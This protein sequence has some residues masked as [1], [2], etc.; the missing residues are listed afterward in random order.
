MIYL[1]W[2]IVSLIFYI[3]DVSIIL[4]KKKSLEAQ[5][6]EKI[7]FCYDGIYEKYVSKWKLSHD[8]LSWKFVLNFFFIFTSFIMSIYLLYKRIKKLV[9][10]YN[11]PY[12]AREIIQK[13]K[14]KNI[15]WW[16]M[17]RLLNK[18]NEYSTEK[19]QLCYDI[20]EEKDIWSIVYVENWNFFV[21]ERFEDNE[22]IMELNINDDDSFHYNLNVVWVYWDDVYEEYATGNKFYWYEKFLYRFS[23][24]KI[25][26]KCENL[27]IYWDSIIEDWRINKKNFWIFL[28]WFRYNNYLD[29]EDAI[30]KE[31]KEQ[32]FSNFSDIMPIHAH[33]LKSY[34]KYILAYLLSLKLSESEFDKYIESEIKKIDEARGKLIQYCKKFKIILEDDDSLPSLIEKLWTDKSKKLLEEYY[35]KLENEIWYSIIDYDWEISVL[36]WFRENHKAFRNHCWQSMYN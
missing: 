22:Y 17:I 7:K 16:E 15:S 20:F 27:N 14:N 19:Y 4:Y 3:I 31:T 35:Y 8:P 36:E 26:A 18:Y 30:K 29:I 28:N 10:Y 13:I 25:Y 11:Q 24:N 23:N 9:K 2:V 32:N 5:N 12:E 21:K 33:I 34:K 1:I 6:F